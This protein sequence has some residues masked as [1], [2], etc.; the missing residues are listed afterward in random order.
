MMIKVDVYLDKVIDFCD[1]IAVEEI[2]THAETRI[3]RSA[4]TLR[5]MLA[6]AGETARMIRGGV[7]G[8]V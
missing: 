8:A 5:L 6:Q 7:E 2:D 4:Q 1:S 3:N